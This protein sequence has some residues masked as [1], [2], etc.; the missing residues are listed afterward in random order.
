MFDKSRNLLFAFTCLTAL[1]GGGITS[2]AETAFDASRLPR[3]SGAK[4]VFASPATTIFTSPDP[5]AQTADRLEKALAA[6]GW[7]QYV[8]PFTAR[9]S[10]P[11]LRI[12]SLKK[13][14]QALNVMVSVA[15]AQNNATSVQYSALPLR[16]DLPFTKDAANIEFDPNRPLLTLITAEPADKTLA[17]YR[18]EL[19][20]RGWS[21]WSAATNG[22]QP[23]GGPAGE[24]HDRGG[25]AHYITDK[26][27]SVT[28]LLTVQKLDGGKAK[29]EIKQMPIGALAG[30]HQA[31]TNSDNRGAALVKVSDLPRLD[32]ADD[33]GRSKPD[34]TVYTVAGTLAQTANAI[35]A[36]LG[37]NGW[38][39]FVVP[40]DNVHT[41]LVRFKKGRQGLTV[42]YT[43][44]PGKNERTSERT[45]ITYSP[46]RLNFAMP[47][48]DDATEV[49]FDENRP[50]LSAGT[51]VDVEATLNFY[52]KELAASGWAPL[53]PV[54]VLTKWPNAKLD[55]KPNDV[56]FI[57]GERRVILLSLQRDGAKTNIEIKVPSFALPQTLEAGSGYYGIPSPKLIK[58]GG[59]TDGRPER[60]MYA[61]VPADIGTVLAF[62]RREL[63]ARHWKEEAQGAV[64]K[65]DEVV[66]NYTPPEGKAVLKLTH[67]YD[68]TIVSIVQQIPKPPVV[69]RPADGMDS[70]GAM[71]KQAE[72]MMRDVPGGLTPPPAPRATADAGAPLHPL[73]DNKAPVP[74]PNN[75]EDIEFDGD[76]GK[77]EFSSASGVKAVADFYR[78][79]MKQ[80]G[81]QSRS[82]VINNANMVVLN[83]AKG[84]KAVSLHHHEDGHQDQRNGGRRRAERCGGRFRQI[85]QGG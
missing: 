33:P 2:Q 13:G 12:M 32:G 65:P 45:T 11:N 10:N 76:D 34:R 51:A 15:P 74:L 60:K 30:L 58:S 79:T 71:L 7:Q 52:M 8:A 44:Q 46:A 36:L 69:A 56:Y 40:L 27:P 82:S 47:L 37:A 57:R 21:L 18:T 85:R 83:F 35:K 48:P 29:V 6:A 78:S 72:Q 70:I 67:K 19:A 20:A 24:M 81:W 31:Y 22:K 38:K 26:N 77:L 9:A 61:H 62:Y 54:D 55:N 84:G 59:A 43:I 42:S 23:A 63:A 53:A 16:T 68:L 3:V 1:A 66:L 49:V 64:I 73:A 50:Y 4:E 39:P 5:V 28:L 17:F 75:A 14:G 25:Y 80:Q 41:T